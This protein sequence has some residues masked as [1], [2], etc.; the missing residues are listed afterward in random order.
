M[1]ASKDRLK[2]HNKR[3]KRKRKNRLTHQCKTYLNQKK[4]QEMKTCQAVRM[5]ST[6]MTGTIMEKKR[7]NMVMWLLKPRNRALKNHSSINRSKT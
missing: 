6:K 4:R 7:T 1:L 2:K 5:T 3:V